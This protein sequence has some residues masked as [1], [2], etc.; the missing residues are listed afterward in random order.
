M[1]NRIP[2]PGIPT[3]KV[4]KSPA[5]A[6][7]AAPKPTVGPKS[8]AETMLKKE[9]AKGNT[10]NFNKTRESIAKKTGTWPSGYTN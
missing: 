3:P 5:A 10:K 2:T 9:I 6:K 8:P 4:T 1:P 7:A